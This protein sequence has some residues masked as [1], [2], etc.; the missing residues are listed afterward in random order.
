[1]SVRARTRL[2]EVEGDP[3]FF[4]ITKRIHNGLYGS[5]GD[6]GELGQAERARYERAAFAPPWADASNL[7]VIPP[8]ID[9][10]SVKNEPMSP[11]TFASSSAMWGCWTVTAAR[12]SFPSS[13]ATGPP[14]GST[15][16]STSS[17]AARR[18]RQRRR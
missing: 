1:M 8:S 7:H 3:E 12:R 15:G 4:A 10:F 13:A 14:A 17:R 18:C 2:Q 11:E 9:P 5:P 16:T 6:G